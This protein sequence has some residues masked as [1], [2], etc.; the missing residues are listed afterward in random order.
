MIYALC[1]V[2]LYYYTYFYVT[3]VP[4]VNQIIYTTNLNE[5]EKHVSSQIAVNYI[6]FQ[7]YF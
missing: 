2:A 5:G 3:V 6:L 1:N 7:K 4:K